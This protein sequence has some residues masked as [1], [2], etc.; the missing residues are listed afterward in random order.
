MI[1]YRGPTEA[2]F[3]RNF[4]GFDYVVAPSGSSFT[5]C[6]T[7]F[8]ITML[9]DDAAVEAVLFGD[10]GVG[11]SLAAGAIHVSMSKPRSASSAFAIPC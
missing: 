11:Q 7:T 3:V 5:M 10:G 9:A 4:S 8:L 2:L 1:H 6:V